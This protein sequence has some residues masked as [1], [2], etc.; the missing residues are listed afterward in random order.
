MSGEHD[1]LE[2]S[3]KPADDMLLSQAQDF[4]IIVDDDVHQQMNSY[5]QT[6]LSRELAGVI[7]GHYEQ[8]GSKV[9]I[10]VIAAIEARDAERQRASVKLTH[11]SWAYIN[12]VKD[13][14]FP[15]LKIVGWFH[16]HPGFGIFL[17]EF[18]RFI[19]KNFFNL[20]WQ[21][22]FVIDP[23][24][25]KE[26]FFCWE[27]KEIK[28]CSFV[29]EEIGYNNGG[30]LLPGY[31][32]EAG[33]DNKPSPVDMY[34][35][36]VD[37]AGTGGGRWWQA[38]IGL[39][40]IFGLTLGSYN[41][42]IKQGQRMHVEPPS[43]EP[44]AATAAVVKNEIP[45]EVIYKHKVRKGDNLWEISEMYYGTGFRYREIAHHNYLLPDYIIQPGQILIIPNVEEDKP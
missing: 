36:K 16:T 17:S 27:G 25:H 44:A 6:D 26:G 12:Q 29:V 9:I 30:Y 37:A 14:M 1:D 21:V 7:L 10:K 8:Q 13:K 3:L 18:D 5:A 15:D 28:P 20:P 41:V 45:V 33:S 11:E 19:H 43:P 4:I 32:S 23:V 24:A 38:I 35:D 42:G 39:V 2:I 31:S 40:L 34:L 22:A